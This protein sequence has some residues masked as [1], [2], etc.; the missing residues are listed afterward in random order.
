MVRP[1][2]TPAGYIDQYVAVTDSGPLGF[3]STI[4]GDWQ[5]NG[6]YAYIYGAPPTCS[7]NLAIVLDCANL[8]N[9]VKMPNPMTWIDEGY[10]VA[11]A[12]APYTIDVF[13][14]GNGTHSTYVDGP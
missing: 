9:G 8:N 13:L 5:Y 12:G 14:Y 3:H 11:E 1:T 10:D 6:T 4:S 7:S 2:A